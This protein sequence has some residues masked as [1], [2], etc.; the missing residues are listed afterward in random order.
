MTGCG[1]DHLVLSLAI[2][3]GDPSYRKY[4][5]TAEATGGGSAPGG[6]K[7]PSSQNSRSFTATSV[8]VVD[9]VGLLAI[10]TKGSECSL[11]STT[12]RPY[13]QR[14]RAS[15]QTAAIRHRLP[16]PPRRRAVP[17]IF[18]SLD[19]RDR[20]TAPIAVWAPAA[21]PEPPHSTTRP[22]ESAPIA[23]TTNPMSH[24]TPKTPWTRHP[25]R[26]DGSKG[27]TQC[28]FIPS[29][30]IQNS[31][32]P[33]PIGRF[34]PIPPTREEGHVT[35]EPSE[36]KAAGRHRLLSTLS[37]AQDQWSSRLPLRSDTEP[38]TCTEHPG[39]IGPFDAGRLPAGTPRQRS[40]A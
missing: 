17:H 7:E 9:E 15:P 30:R 34:P 8:L 1:K 28:F 18:V 36:R 14:S 35:S 12:R 23:R 5:A 3:A 20:S 2:Q 11:T 32:Y 39:G 40:K 10:H 19:P 37:P 16:G 25:H 31:A 38:R 22:R 27:E 24:F 26:F 13:T 6:Q 33:L 21:A 29:E 4:F